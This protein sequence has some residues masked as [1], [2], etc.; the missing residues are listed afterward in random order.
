MRRLS[1][2]LLGGGAIALGLRELL[3]RRSTGPDHDAGTQR[4]TC[5]CGQEYEIVGTGR[6]RVVW[7]AGGDQRDA[8]MGD[9]CPS[10]GRA[11]A[12]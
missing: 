4:W 1:A 10:C 8:V 3:R 12:A 6:H 2:L 7:P 9:E 5:A 11:L